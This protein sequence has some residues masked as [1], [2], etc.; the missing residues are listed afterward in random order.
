MD[1]ITQEQSI[2]DLVNSIESLQSFLPEKLTKNQKEKLKTL[3]EK[4]EVGTINFAVIGQFKRGK[5]SFIN[6]LLGENIL[7]TGVI[8]LTS[9][10][11]IVK[12]AKFPFSKI[13]FEDNSYK[14]LSSFTGLGLY[15]SEKENPL[16]VKRVKYAEVGFPNE[17][18]NKGLVF[19]DTP[20][21]GSLHLNNTFSTYSH[22]PKIDGAIFITSS[23]PAF[24]EAELRLLERVST[25]TPTVFFV[26]NKIDYLTPLDL[27]QILT[28][29]QEL[30]LKFYRKMDIIIFPVSAQNALLAKSTGNTQMLDRSG[31]KSFETYLEK[32][33]ILRRK[34]ILNKS[35]K[36][37]LLN[38]I[39]EVETSF[40][41]ETSSYQMSIEEINSKHKL[42]QESVD[43]FSSDN[44]KFLK[45]GR[46]DITNLLLLYNNYF[47]S[48]KSELSKKI[49]NELLTFESKNS[50]LSRLKFKK[51]IELLFHTLIK[52][53]LEKQRLQIENEIQEEAK[54][55]FA[56]TINNYNS[57]INKIYKAT[58]NL[59]RI[60]LRE[61]HFEKNIEPTT[62]FEYITYEFKLMVNFNWTK[63]VFLLPRHIH[64]R[65]IVKSYFNR[66]DFTI[67]YNF[68]YIIDDIKKKLER[69]LIEY[70]VF[71]KEQIKDTIEKLTEII[72]KIKAIKQ[73][74]EKITDSI[75]S[76]AADK[77]LKL[78]EIKLLLTK[79]D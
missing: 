46:E 16:N 72:E 77:I 61:V 14:I 18:L 44:V 17:L 55:I 32:Y 8:P 43:Y 66:I 10:V 53:S 71:F 30:F 40:E 13:V 64:N 1:I 60:P 27:D 33:V 6:A 42:L 50:S 48:I 67:N 19:V 38:I 35:V 5:S 15:T 65:L 62:E 74:E 2:K 45:E 79:K 54:K 4:L 68:N 28:Y 22:L 37:Q 12:Y 73:K 41:L 58:A 49:H 57:I 20:G 11:T 21:I 31:I 39:N 23:D 24:S 29:T 78:E 51:K 70:N 36:R 59:F 26:L 7:P 63:L 69:T 47:E 76:E 9:I 3:R 25:I 75:L 34:N 52:T 56:K